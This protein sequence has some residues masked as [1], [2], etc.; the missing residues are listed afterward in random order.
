[1]KYGKLSRDARMR[2][3]LKRR[4]NAQHHLMHPNQTRPNRPILAG[5]KSLIERLIGA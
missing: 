1:M 3:E 4:G 5:E 2:R